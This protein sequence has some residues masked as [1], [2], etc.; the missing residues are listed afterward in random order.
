MHTEEIKTW[1][2]TVSDAVSILAIGAAALWFLTT[3]KFKPRIQ[4]DLDCNFLP[5]NEN[6]DSLIAELQF[7][8]EN[9]GFVEHRLYNLNVSV[10]TLQSDNDLPVKPVT[11][12]LLFNRQLL[13]R[14]SIV[15]K[16][17]NFYFVRPGT[18]QVITHIMVFPKS[19]SVIRVTASFD[20][21][22]SRRW[23]HTARRVFKVRIPQ[24]ASV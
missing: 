1:I 7:I 10:H 21:G 4:F 5:I 8:F 24:D 14:V 12:E 9:K 11:K 22:D 15:R 20:Y 19:I 6:N 2:S 17:Y 13:P 16:A 18:R 23:P 3:T